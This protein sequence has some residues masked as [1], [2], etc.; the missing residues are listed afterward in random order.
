MNKYLPGQMLEYLEY[1]D[2][3]KMGQV[4]LIV[5]HLSYH[6]FSRN[7]LEKYD[8]NII[9]EKRSNDKYI[10][11]VKKREELQELDTKN[12]YSPLL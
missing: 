4:I 1:I 2:F 5:S 12:W 6:C 3:G 10:I 9:K 7:L 11:H 8:N